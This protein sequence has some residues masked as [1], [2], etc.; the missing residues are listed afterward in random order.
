MNGIAVGPDVGDRV[1]LP[2]GIDV[3]GADGVDVGI[4]VAIETVGWNVGLGDGAKVSSHP[5]GL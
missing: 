3:G 2:V 4:S 5:G 1:G